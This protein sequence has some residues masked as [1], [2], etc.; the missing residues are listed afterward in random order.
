LVS[1]QNITVSVV[2]FL[3]AA[4]VATANGIN[5]PAAGAGEAGMA[6]V[7]IMKP[8]L[9]ASFHNQASLAYCHNTAFSFSY[10]SRFGIKELSVK[11]ACLIIPAGNGSA[12]LFYSRSGFT[13]YRR[14]VTGLASALKLAPGLSAGVQIDLLAEHQ[15]G[16]YKDYLQVSCEAGLIYE[17][18]HDIRMGIHIFNPVPNSLRNVPVPSSIR[19]GAGIS[20]SE[21]LFAGLEAEMI[22]GGKLNIR[23]GF[24]YK[25]VKNAS[26]R[27]GYST[28]EPSFSFGFGWIT[29]PAIVDI[30]FSTHPRLGVTSCFSVSFVSGKKP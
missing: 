26:L 6:Y 14:E 2:I 9:W 4:S 30:A 8:G 16:E 17:I 18:S 21:S 1:L 20:I 22:S 27:C 10:E 24:E 28:A 19:T 15:Q 5:R 13:D 7:C 25:T 23:T 11:S 12:G 3:S 29:G